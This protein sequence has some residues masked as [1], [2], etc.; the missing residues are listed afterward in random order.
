VPLSPRAPPIVSVLICCHAFSFVEGRY[1]EWTPR[2]NASNVF[3]FEVCERSWHARQKRASPPSDNP[4]KCRGERHSLPIQVAIGRNDVTS[5]AGASQSKRSGDRVRLLFV[6]RQ[7]NDEARVEVAK[8]VERPRCISSMLPTA[9][10]VNQPSLLLL[11][12]E[13]ADTRLLFIH[14]VCSSWNP[15]SCR[16]AASG[17]IPTTGRIFSLNRWR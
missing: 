15:T 12:D 4:I 11:D 10:K 16:S 14:H 1:S 5:V 6:R 13:R 8:V 9:E 3:I 7:S 2:Q 17:A